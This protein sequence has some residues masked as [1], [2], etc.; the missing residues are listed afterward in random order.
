MIV[1]MKKVYLVVLESTRE[2]ALEKM[3]ELGV[4]HQENL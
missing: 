2:K 3:R 4:V 1:K